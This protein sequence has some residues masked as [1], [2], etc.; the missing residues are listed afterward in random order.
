MWRTQLAFFAL[1][2]ALALGWTACTADVDSGEGVLEGEAAMVAPRYDLF[3]TY[4]GESK[5]FGAI[6]LLVLKSDGTYHRGIVV[7]CMPSICTPMDDDGTYQLWGREGGNYISFYPDDG[8]PVDR[9]QYAT[10][11]D[12]IR[13]R[14]M[15]ERGAFHL[16]KTI[17][18]A[19]CGE[20]ADCNVQGLP[21]GPCSG[22]D[23]YCMT[24]TETCRYYCRPPL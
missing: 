14:R 17:N 7:P 8:G 3:G 16:H 19:W 11:G 23:Y 6:T 15:T 2:P 13:M 9:F 4:R 24:N 5:Q 22:G 18:S 1:V 20:P 21:P 12:T 10:A